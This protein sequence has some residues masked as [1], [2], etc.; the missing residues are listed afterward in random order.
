MVNS[1]SVA[2][3]SIPVYFAHFLGY[4]AAIKPNAIK[5]V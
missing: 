5:L 3:G 1:I 4:N 2:F